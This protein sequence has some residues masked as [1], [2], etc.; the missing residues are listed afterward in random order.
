MH[1][2]RPRTPKDIAELYIQRSIPPPGANRHT[3]RVDK[4]PGVQCRIYS[5]SFC[6]PRGANVEN[7]ASDSVLR[8][9]GRHLGRER[10]A[11]VCMQWKWK[12]RK[13]SWPQQV[14]GRP[15]PY[16]RSRTA[17]VSDRLWCLLAGEAPPQSR[18]TPEFRGRINLAA[19]GNGTGLSPAVPGNGPLGQSRAAFC[20]YLPPLLRT[21]MLP[22]VI[23]GPAGCLVVIR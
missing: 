2:Q 19:G 17:S 5:P 14:F 6:N 23:A 11:S 8:A 18:L 9:N 15:R 10:S 22:S 20:V 3:W 7:F 12:L 4:A 21:R 13:R 1:R 16:R